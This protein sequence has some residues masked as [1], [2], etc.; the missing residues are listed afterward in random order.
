MSIRINKQLNISD[1][2]HEPKERI[3]ITGSIMGCPPKVWPRAS[4]SHSKMQKMGYELDVCTTQLFTRGKNDRLD[5][6][7]DLD[8]STLLLEDLPGLIHTIGQQTEMRLTLLFKEV[9]ATT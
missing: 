9:G 3:S 5:W 8:T 2:D 1:Y 4:V 7:A 6:L